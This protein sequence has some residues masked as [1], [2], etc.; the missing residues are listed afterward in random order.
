[1]PPLWP[2]SPGRPDP[3]PTHTST[4]EGSDRGA[5]LI[6]QGEQFRV[7]ARPLANPV[8]AR[9]DAASRRFGGLASAVTLTSKCFISK[10]AYQFSQ[11]I[12]WRCPEWCGVKEPLNNSLH[13]Q[14]FRLVRPLGQG[15]EGR[16]VEGVCPPIETLQQR[17]R[18]SL[19]DPEGGA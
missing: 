17:V 12:T 5:I 3:S 15:E 2:H 8:Q 1:M 18:A 11:G 4:G 10:I 16:N 7:I 13:T 19:E 9:K 6:Q 14:S